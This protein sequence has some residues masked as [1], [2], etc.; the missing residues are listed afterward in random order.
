MVDPVKFLA[1]SRLIHELPL[2]NKYN[3]HAVRYKFFYESSPRKHNCSYARLT[4]Q[5]FETSGEA[6]LLEQELLLLQAT[7][8]LRLLKELR[9]QMIQ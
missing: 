6:T 7:E 8:A 3:Y 4:R 5:H 1:F 9:C 2:E